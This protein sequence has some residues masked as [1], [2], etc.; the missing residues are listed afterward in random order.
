MMEGLSCAW[1]GNRILGKRSKKKNHSA[2]RELTFQWGGVCVYV[3]IR[4]YVL[5]H[6]IRQYILH[7]VKNI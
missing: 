3:D 2:F 4:V 1:P 5:H 6:E 7:W